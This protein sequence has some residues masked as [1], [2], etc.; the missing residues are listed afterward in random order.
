MMPTLDPCQTKRIAHKLSLMPT[1][2]NCVDGSNEDQHK[3][4]QTLRVVAQKLLN[5]AKKKRDNDLEPVTT[6]S[7]AKPVVLHRLSTSTFSEATAS[8]GDSSSNSAE[9]AIS[10]NHALVNL[11]GEMKYNEI[12][13]VYE[14]ISGIRK[15]SAVWT[16]FSKEFGRTRL[17]EV[18]DYTGDTTHQEERA[19]LSETVPLPIYNLYF[20]VR[21]VDVMSVVASR[22]RI[23]LPLP[24]DDIIHRTDWDVLLEDA[25]MKLKA[26]REF[27]DTN[28]SPSDDLA[29][30]CGGGVMCSF[31][32]PQKK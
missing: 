31:P 21:L 22:P 10:S 4:R 6:L 14:E 25:K 5:I 9:L 24:S 13:N 23:V 19:P 7:T 12:V 30:G 3:L 18:K 17:K 26:F 28:V 27:E 29:F 8:S 15:T 11:L 1:I 2:W 16:K 20:R 32:S